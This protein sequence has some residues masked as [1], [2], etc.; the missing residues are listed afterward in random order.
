MIRQVE[1]D[2]IICRISKDRIWVVIEQN[3]VSKKEC[4]NRCISCAGSNNHVKKIIVKVNDIKA[5]KTGQR[6]TVKRYMPNEMISA[7]VVFGI[8][9]FLPLITML[10]WYSVSP[11]MAESAEAFL[12]ALGAL[13]VGFCLVG[14][15]DTLFRK[16]FPAVIISAHGIDI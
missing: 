16:F 10:T 9:I 11:G 13:L 5:L 12:S 3:C 15:V 7:F 2:G 6:I 4:T 8:P 14:I 1:T